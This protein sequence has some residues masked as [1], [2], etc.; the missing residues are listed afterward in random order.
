MSAALASRSTPLTSGF[1]RRLRLMLLAFVALAIIVF[2]VVSDHLLRT[3]TC[4]LHVD[5]ARLCAVALIPGPNGD[6]AESFDTLRARYDKLIAVATLDADGDLSTVYPPRPAYRRAAQAMVAS[7]THSTKLPTGHGGELISAFGTVVPLNGSDSPAAQ[8]AVILLQHDHDHRAWLRAIIWFAAALCVAAL[9][10]AESLR[11]WFDRSVTRTLRSV[12][13]SSLSPADWSSMSSGVCSEAWQE[14]AE[15][16]IRFRELLQS[17]KTAEA[18][19]SQVQREAE[20]RMRERQIGFDRELRRA[21]DRATLDPLTRLRNRRFFEEKL[22]PLF[23][24]CR[25]EEKELAAVMIDIDDFKHYNDAHGH[26]VGD[27]LLRFAG[28]LLRGAIRPTDYAIRYGGDEFLLL[29]PGV[30][31]AQIQPIAKRLVKLFSQY[32][33]RLGHEH[34]LSISVGIATLATG[35]PESGHALVAEADTA[36]YAAKRK[37]KGRVVGP[38]AA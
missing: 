25:T 27:A 11:R 5:E 26:Q 16:A 31:A 4:S 22:E 6:L 29:M 30:P 13:V 21:R 24:G 14:T 17:A 7:G 9:F 35:T 32:A 1:A 15:I 28:A 10:A 23:N 19:A 8:K 18:R 37:G 33:R 20:S 12:V 34:N 38:Y 36:M 2:G 3:H